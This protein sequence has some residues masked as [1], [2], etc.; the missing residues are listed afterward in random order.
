MTSKMLSAYGI[1]GWINERTNRNYKISEHAS[2][3]ALDAVFTKT[4]KKNVFI[5]TVPDNITVGFRFFTQQGFYG[6][7]MSEQNDYWVIKC[8]KDINYL[9]YAIMRKEIV[10]QRY[11]DRFF[12][13]PKGESDE[14]NLQ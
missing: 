13:L 5:I 11:I 6:E 1:Q 12:V 7:V 10:D 3:K 4:A 9:D 8:P 2:E 14:S